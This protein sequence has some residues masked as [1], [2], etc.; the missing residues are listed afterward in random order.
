[1]PK[2]IVLLLLTLVLTALC[3]NALGDAE[4]HTVYFPSTQENTA[5]PLAVTTDFDWFDGDAAEY[6]HG[7]ARMSIAM[8]VAA[9]RDVTVELTDSDHYLRTFFDELGFE[10]YRALGYDQ[11]P[12][13]TTISNAFAYKRLE[14]ED[15]PYVLLAVPVCG[16]GYGDEWLSNFAVYDG[17]EHAGFAFS[18]DLVLTRLQAYVAQELPGERIKVWITGFSRAAAVSNLLGYRLLSK[19]LFAEDSVFVYTFGTPNVTT[20]YFYYPQ[21]NNIVGSFDP[22]PKIPLKEWGY[23]KHGRVL[24]LPSR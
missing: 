22:V 23:D 5:T 24:V 6:S 16:Q 13:G 17:T 20:E 15:G 19:E 14:D 3:A 12:S 21:I 7:L 2:K 18:A 10:G 1:M 11:T 9:F 4:E 8:A